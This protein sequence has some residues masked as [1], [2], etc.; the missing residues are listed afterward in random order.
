MTCFV[1]CF[2]NDTAVSMGWAVGVDG[3]SDGCIGVV[4]RW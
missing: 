2:R 3:R 4:W 1:W